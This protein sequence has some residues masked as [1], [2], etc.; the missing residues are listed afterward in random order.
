MRVDAFS[1]A[2][3]ENKKKVLSDGMTI[4]SGCSAKLMPFEALQN[5]MHMH[6]STRALLMIFTMIQTQNILY[7]ERAFAILSKHVWTGDA[8]HC[9][10]GQCAR[11][12]VSQSALGSLFA[13]HTRNESHDR[14][15]AASIEYINLLWPGRGICENVLLHRIHLS[16]MAHWPNAEAVGWQTA[17]VPWYPLPQ[18]T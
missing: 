4:W 14:H 9:A 7:W 3:L 12:F 17:D 16:Q 8:H 13:H 5:R 10:A 15:P 6:T 11:S 18:R 2:I 1:H